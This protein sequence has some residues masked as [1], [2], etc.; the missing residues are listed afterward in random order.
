MNVDLASTHSPT[1][2][3][4]AVLVGIV[5]AARITRLLTEDTFPPTV[6]LRTWYMSKVSEEWGKLAICPWCLGPWIVALDGLAAI[7]T[8]LHPAWYVANVWFAAAYVASWLV[9]HDEDGS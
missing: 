2:L 7:S 4:V 8:D 1:A 6:A 3:W 9:Y 5:A